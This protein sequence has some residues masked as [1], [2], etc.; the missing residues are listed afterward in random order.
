ME[1]TSTCAHGIIYNPAELAWQSVGKIHEIGISRRSTNHPWDNYYYTRLCNFS[2]LI[3][4]HYSKF[5]ELT[6]QTSA[7]A[8]PPPSRIS[9]PHDIFVCTDFQSNR[10]GAHLGI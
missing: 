8:K 5:Y 1:A 3:N 10:G 2:M 4:N 7:R 6:S 9:T